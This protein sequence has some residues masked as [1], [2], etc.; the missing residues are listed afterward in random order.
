MTEDPPLSPIEA[1]T[2]MVPFP[3]VSV[4]VGVPGTVAGSASTGVDATE[5]PT[6]LTAR[7]STGYSVPLDTGVVPSVDR[8]VMTIGLAFEEA[9]C[10][11]V[12]ASV[13]YW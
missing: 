9:V 3:G 1:A 13:E 5:S 8:V 11:V 4:T 2:E 10:Q 6:A 12:P 7:I